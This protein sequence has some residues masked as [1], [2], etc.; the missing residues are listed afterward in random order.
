MTMA[1]VLAVHGGRSD[2]G[3][4]GRVPVFDGFARIMEPALYQRLP[5]D[6]LIGLGDIVGST[7]AIAAGRYKTVNT[8][9]AALIA[10]VANALGG[11]DFPFVFGGDGAS[12]AVPPEDAPTAQDALAATAAWAR[13]ELDLELRVALVPMA[14]VRAAGRDVRVARFAPS[15]HLSYAMFTGGGLAWAEQ[16]L[17]RG[18]FA[19]PAAPSGVRPDLTGLS[20]RWEAIPALHGTVLSLIVTPAAVERIGPFR[21][22]VEEILALVEAAPQAGRPQPIMASSLRWPPSGLEL[23]AR[24]ARRP[25]R[26]L[27]WQRL[28]L[29]AHTLLAF[30]VF[31]LHLPAGRFD[32]DRYRRELTMNADFRK[33]DDGLRMTL[34]CTPALAD[35]IEERLAA[36]ERAGIARFGVHRQASALMTCFVPNIHDSGHVHFIDGAAGGYAEAARRMKAR[37]DGQGGPVS[38]G[39]AAALR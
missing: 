7:A 24:A 34:D 25:G 20:C 1:T 33:Y 30:V 21:A 18:A 36:A 6:W 19:V 9:G 3:F 4:Y 23:E 14:A 2:S 35:R 37:G 39:R 11:R 16:A 29:L 17:K 13:D 26:P 32:P 5:D 15:P 31:R 38:L 12:F 10:A 22:L 27:V 8:A 28:R